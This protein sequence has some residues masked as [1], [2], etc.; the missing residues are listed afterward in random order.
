MSRSSS[1]RGMG[2]VIVVLVVLAVVFDLIR[3]NSFLLGVGS[4]PDVPEGTQ[5]ERTIDRVQRTRPSRF[6]RPGSLRPDPVVSPTGI[7]V[8]RTRI[9]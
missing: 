5:L 8:T 1:R 2:L 4:G 7:P 9:G 3:P 6:D